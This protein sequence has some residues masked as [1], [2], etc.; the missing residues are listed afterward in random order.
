M[1]PDDHI[2]SSFLFVHFLPHP[3]SLSS[4]SV[5]SQPERRKTGL[6]K[7]GSV[8]NSRG[9]PEERHLYCFLPLGN[10]T[11]INR[12]AACRTCKFLVFEK[13][14]RQDLRNYGKDIIPFSV[15]CKPRTWGICRSKLLVCCCCCWFFQICCHYP[16]WFPQPV[17]MCKKGAL[18]FSEIRM[19]SV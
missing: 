2:C 5:I 4:P 17:W 13:N 3:T 6:L 14:P 16:C 12:E 18:L 19:G 15:C 11:K 8:K 9:Y 7:G 10:R 1:S